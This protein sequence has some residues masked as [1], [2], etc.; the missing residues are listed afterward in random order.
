M[1]ENKKVRETNSKM[2]LK[3]LH[4]FHHMIGKEVK[5]NLNNG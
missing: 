5:V 4:F 1:N 2:R 3:S